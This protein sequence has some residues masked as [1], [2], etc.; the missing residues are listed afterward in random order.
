MGSSGVSPGYG[1]STFSHAEEGQA[2][3]RGQAERS[4][5]GGSGESPP[6]TT[7]HSAPTRRRRPSAASRPIAAEKGGSG[8]SPDY[9]NF[10]SNPTRTHA[11]EGQA[12]RSGQA[13][14][15]G[16]RDPLDFNSN[17]RS[18]KNSKNKRTKT[19]RLHYKEAVALLWFSL[20]SR[21]LCVA[22]ENIRFLLIII[23][24]AT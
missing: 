15:S 13:E 5:E 17:Q 21:C 8:V 14:L 3:R 16:N 7:Q 24:W 22:R 9:G 4:G 18:A 20:G 11:E 10:D 19:S 1:N 6:T 12:E 2:E 23:K